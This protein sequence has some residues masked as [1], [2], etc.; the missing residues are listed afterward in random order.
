[1]EIKPKSIFRRGAEDGAKFGIYL[2]VLFIFVAYS[3]NV[4]LLGYLSTF[5]ALGVPVYAYITL[6]KGYRE[7]GCFYTFAEMW[8]YGI[9]LF[10]CGALIMAMT[11]VVYTSWIN[12]EFIYEQCQI[13]IEA[14]KSLNNPMATEIVSTLEK[15][16][17]QNLLPSPTQLAGNLFSFSVFSGSILTIIITPIIRYFNNRMKRNGN[18][19]KQ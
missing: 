13:A 16:M 5:M 9:V 6:S 3:L 4:P 8:T 14:Y 18:S 10:A 11:I 7:N 15:V 1:M 12:P 17:E 2:S 19:I